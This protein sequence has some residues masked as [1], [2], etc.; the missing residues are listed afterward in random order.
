MNPALRCGGNGRERYRR[1]RQAV[2]RAGVRG[3]F[4]RSTSVPCR[5]AATWGGSSGPAS[6]RSNS[7]ATLLAAGDSRACRPT[8]VAGAAGGRAADPLPARVHARASV[9]QG[10]QSRRPPGR[11]ARDRADGGDDRARLACGGQRPVQQRR[12]RPG[13]STRVRRVD[14][15]LTAAGR[16]ALGRFAARSGEPLSRLR[17]DPGR[18]IWSTG[19]SAPS[20]PTGFRSPTSPMSARGA[21]SPMWLSSPTCS[22]ATS[23]VGRSQPLCE[24]SSHSTP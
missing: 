17:P 15:R 4:S 10:T 7:S 14:Y 18:P 2:G 22:V 9:T 6:S 12:C 3:C 8:R 21:E 23:L 16:R 1:G 20:H 19:T 11:Q 5:R 24:R 13:G